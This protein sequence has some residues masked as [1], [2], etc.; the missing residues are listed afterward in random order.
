LDRTGGLR[1][2]RWVIYAIIGLLIVLLPWRV[3][4]QWKVKSQE[5]ENLRVTVIIVLAAAACDVC[6]ADFMNAR[7]Q[8]MESRVALARIDETRIAHR[9]SA[10]R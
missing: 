3:A 5:A 1:A 2:D 9:L 4:T 10:V 6:L 8:P 7:L